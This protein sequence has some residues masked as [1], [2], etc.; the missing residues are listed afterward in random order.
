MVTG[1]MAD[2]HPAVLHLFRNYKSPSDVLQEAGIHCEE[3]EQP[4]P[5]P[6]SSF[7][8]PLKPC[9]IASYQT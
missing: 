4:S 9:G 2:R 5:S 1:V 6:S 7:T 3:Q 8:T